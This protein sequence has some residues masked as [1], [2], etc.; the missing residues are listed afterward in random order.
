MTRRLGIFCATLAS[1]LICL[2]PASIAQNS[3]PGWRNDWSLA[4]GF[5]IDADTTDFNFPSDIEFIPNPGTAPG[6]PLY[7]TAR[8]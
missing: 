7:E 6:D 8:R 3:V 5:A 1:G 2:L 4:P